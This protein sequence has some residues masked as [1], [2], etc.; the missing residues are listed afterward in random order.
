MLLRRR[1]RNSSQ[2]NF[3][4]FHN[5]LRIEQPEELLRYLCNL[6]GELETRIKA[7]EQEVR[8]YLQ[9]LARQGQTPEIGTEGICYCCRR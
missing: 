4:G 8:K 7:R 5:S 9:E 2:G 3:P 1:W 6:D